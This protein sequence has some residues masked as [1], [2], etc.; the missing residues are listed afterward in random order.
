MTTIVIE[1]LLDL[2]RDF[3]IFPDAPTPS[4]ELVRLGLVPPLVVMGTY[5]VWG[6]PLL[7]VAEKIGT[8]EL[9]VREIETDI[10]GA[11][12][13]ALRLENRVDRFTWR[14]KALLLR[15]ISDR[16]DIGAQREEIREIEALVQTEGSF[17]PGTKKFECL[18]AH[19]KELAAAELID[20]KTAEQ[21]TVLPEKVVADLLKAVKQV[22]FSAR[23]QLLVMFAEIIKRDRLSDS[24]AAERAGRLLEAPDP[25]AEVRRLRYPGLSE[26]QAAF[27]SFRERYV[28]GSGVEIVPPQNF[29]GGSFGVRFSW[30]S[31]KQFQRVLETLHRLEEK[32]DELFR[33]LF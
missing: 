24:A 21:I 32:G 9:Q 29:E 19:I 20:L 25:I 7:E 16:P 26:L 8:A 1:E 17:I 23:R 4:A 2:R 15:F 18:P 14:E 31:D 11:L 28:K 13:T 27:D 6:R 3:D 33:L 22:S 10:T 12:K 5:L 30:R